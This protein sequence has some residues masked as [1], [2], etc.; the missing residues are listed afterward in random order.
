M[1]RAKAKGQISIIIRLQ[2]HIAL[3][4]KQALS[5]MLPPIWLLRLL[6]GCRRN[7][8]N[9]VKALTML[10]VPLTQAVLGSISKGAQNDSV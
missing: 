3:I 8:K 1:I 2:A 9:F 4:I 5:N 6:F 10:E 7:K